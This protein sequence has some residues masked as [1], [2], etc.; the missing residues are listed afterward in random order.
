[1]TLHFLTC[2]SFL[3]AKLLLPP[4][5]GRDRHVSASAPLIIPFMGALIGGAGRRRRQET[6]MYD[7][8]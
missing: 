3:P 2:G 6:F 8:T 4:G 1:M 7:A 5:V